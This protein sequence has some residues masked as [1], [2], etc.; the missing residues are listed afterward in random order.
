LVVEYFTGKNSSQ[1]SGSYSCS[2]M[3][4]SLLIGKEKMKDLRRRLNPYSPI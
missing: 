4:V 2:K 3:F 1:G